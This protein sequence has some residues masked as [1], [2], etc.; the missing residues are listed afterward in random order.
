[1]VHDKFTKWKD[2]TNL[3]PQNALGSSTVHQG[4]GSWS[5]TSTS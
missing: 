2:S 4:K 3:N 1:M 5:T